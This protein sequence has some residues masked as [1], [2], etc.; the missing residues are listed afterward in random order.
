MS[1]FNSLEIL[2]Q[3]ITILLNG[4]HVTFIDSIMWA[5][6]KPIFG[7]PFYILFIYL[8]FKNYNA[9]SAFTIILLMG[10]T[11]G[12][13]DFIAHELVKETIQRYRPSHNLEI[14]HQLNFV[15]NYKGGQFGFVSN[16]ATNMTVVGLL[17]F[18]RMDSWYHFVFMFLQNF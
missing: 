17:T 14:S 3:K 12:L 5:V 7:F 9:K 18:W 11:V 10:L 4:S 8:F 1:W 13:G 15:N 6:S 2:D 16:H